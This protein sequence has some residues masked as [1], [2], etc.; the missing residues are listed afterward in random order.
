MEGALL[1]ALLVPSPQTS[2]G[3]ADALS[4]AAAAR[5]RGDYATAKRLYEQVLAAEPADGRA[6]VGLADTLVD[7]GDAVAAQKLLQPVVRS[8][9]DRPE[10]RRAL[11][12][13]YLRGGRA[14]DALAEASRAVEAAPGD[15]A[16]RVVLGLAQSATGSPEK[17][18]ESLEKALALSPG[19]RGALAGLASVYAAVSDLRAEAAYEKAVAADPRNL[20]LAVE[21]ADFLWR[22]KRYDRGNAVMDR[23]LREIPDNTRLR[24]H[25]G[26]TLADQSRFVDAVRQFDEARRRDSSAEVLFY[27]GSALWEVGRFDDAATRLREA[28]S[29]SPD[30]ASYRH[31][32]G[33][34]ELFRGRRDDALRELEK[35]AAIDPKSAEIALDLGRAYEANGRSA[36]AE[37]AYRRALALEPE[38]SVTHYTLGTLLART[39]RREEASREIGAY[40]EYFQ[41]EQA[42]RHRGASKQAEI[43]LGWTELEAGRAESA[44]EHFAKFSGDVEALR[45]AAQA[46]LK[47]GRAGEAVRTL[48]RALLLEPENHALVWEL[49]RARSRGAT[50]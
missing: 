10:P 14:Q 18:V 9:P 42:S 35:A 29:Q 20:P 27:L 47:L 40:Q 25:Y 37:A 30:N 44:L 17:A 24:V 31:R 12:R 16:S 43:N 5:T 26:L 34:L 36:E 22:E 8:L 4:R 23:V 50:P 6:A 19:D 32:L 33:R 15:A 1:F 3:P 13:A 7:L 38:L 48:E 46:L 11:A 2:P 28:V 21:Y 41:K 45:G 39:G 49:D